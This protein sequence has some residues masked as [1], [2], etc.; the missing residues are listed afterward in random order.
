MNESVENL[1]VVLTYSYV[2]TQ[3]KFVKL[4][5]GFHQ[6][7]VNLTVAWLIIWLVDLNMMSKRGKHVDYIIKF[8]CEN[9]YTLANFV[10][11]VWCPHSHTCLYVCRVRTVL[12]SLWNPRTFF[13]VFDSLWKLTLV[14][15]LKLVLFTYKLLMCL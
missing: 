6:V 3:I 1:Y 14:K 13:Q 15:S 7:K 2:K 11:F 9:F 8:T 10:P 5:W 4:H 12:E